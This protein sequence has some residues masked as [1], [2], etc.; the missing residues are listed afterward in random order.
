MAVG[1]ACLYS[2]VFKLV[3]K[4]L[5]EGARQISAAKL[6]QSR[7]ATAKKELLLADDIENKIISLL[8]FS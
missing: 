5:S 6:F 7:G 8:S 4:A 2:H 1:K 3:L